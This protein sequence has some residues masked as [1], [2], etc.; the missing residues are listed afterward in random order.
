VERVSRLALFS[1]RQEEEERPPRYLIAVAESDLGNGAQSLIDFSCAL[2]KM[3]SPCKAYHSP[4]PNDD[5][6]R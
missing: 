6:R 3:P 4:V 1:R 5:N 2:F